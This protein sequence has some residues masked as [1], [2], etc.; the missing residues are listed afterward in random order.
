MSITR[1]GVLTP[2]EA[3]RLEAEGEPIDRIR[4]SPKYVQF[5]ELSI[6][7]L[8]AI[9]WMVALWQFN[10]ITGAIKALQDQSGQ[11]SSQ[12]AN[13][14]NTMST[15]AMRQDS[16]V[17]A[18]QAAVLQ[19]ERTEK[20]TRML[21]YYLLELDAK[22]ISAGLKPADQSIAQ[23]LAQKRGEEQKP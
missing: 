11:Q 7:G 17:Q 14:N 19:F 5:L 15:L 4:R 10:E 1:P 12:M 22:F 9:L 18:A 3:S 13:L 23:K 2:E 6:K 8:G 20:E 16:A 21:E